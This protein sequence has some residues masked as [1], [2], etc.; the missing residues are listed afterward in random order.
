MNFAAPDG[1]CAPHP[2]DALLRAHLRSAVLMAI[3]LTG[4]VVLTIAAWVGVGYTEQLRST[5][6]LLPYALMAAMALWFGLGAW[7]MQKHQQHVLRCDRSYHAYLQR[8]T[9][10]RKPTV[11][12]LT[13][14]EPSEL[15]AFWS[16]EWAD[17]VSTQPA[18]TTAAP[19]QPT[20]AMPH[21]AHADNTAG[22]TTQQPLEFELI[23]SMT[24]HKPLRP[25]SLFGAVQ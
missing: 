23:A 9:V 13:S 19:A 6:V 1:A 24:E 17:A 10:H 18:H 11:A 15:R 22:H 12:D 4:G 16:H 21:A 8:N 14:D 25:I 20:T 5:W 7:A 2:A 3:Y